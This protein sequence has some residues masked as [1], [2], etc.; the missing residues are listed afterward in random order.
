MT[1]RGR[2]CKWKRRKSEENNQNICPSVLSCIVC[3]FLLFF[4]M[5]QLSEIN[6]LNWLIKLY[7]MSGWQTAIQGDWDHL[8]HQSTGDEW[9]KDVAVHVSNSNPHLSDQPVRVL[10]SD[11]VTTSVDRCRRLRCRHVPRVVGSTACRRRWRRRRCRR[12]DE[13]CQRQHHWTSIIYNASEPL[14]IGVVTITIRLRYDYD[15]TTTKNWHVRFLL[16]SNCVEWKQARAILR[17]R[18]VIVS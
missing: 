6:E 12:A 4:Y 13:N 2:D 11:V 3:S 1:K 18:I 9:S 17:S 5:D 8:R 14:Q 10:F 16:A 7:R 15:T